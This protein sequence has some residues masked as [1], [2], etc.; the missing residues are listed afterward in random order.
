MFLSVI[1]RFADMATTA[2][3]ITDTISEVV[4]LCRV[5]GVTLLVTK[6]SLHLWKTNTV[7]HVLDFKT[8]HKTLIWGRIVLVSFNCPRSQ[9]YL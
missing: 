1:Q 9:V 4:S 7:S 3:Y 5:L 8:T 2:V 6:G